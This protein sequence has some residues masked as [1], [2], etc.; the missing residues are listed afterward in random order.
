VGEGYQ[1]LKFGLFIFLFSLTVFS[2]TVVL[3]FAAM[4]GSFG[5]GWEV[6]YTAK[7]ATATLVTGAE[8]NDI[9]RYDININGTTNI[10]FD[11][12]KDEY[13]DV[14]NNAE[15]TYDVATADSAAD[16]ILYQITDTDGVLNLYILSDSEIFANV[17]C[18]SMFSVLLYMSNGN[19]VIEI[20]FNNFNT[21]KVENMSA[22]FNQSRAF[23]DIDLS[24]WDTSS[25]TDMSYMFDSASFN[26]LNLSGWDTSNVTSMSSMFYGYGG[27][28]ALDISSFDT[29]KVTSMT[30]MFSMCTTVKTI[31]VGSGWS[32]ASVTDGSGMFNMCRQLVGGDGT[33]YNSSYTNHTYARVDTAS[34]PGYF[35]LKS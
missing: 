9:L 13:N 24:G 31:Y 4:S 22:M 16:V 15:M 28:S 18:S 25:V 5:N 6:N 17:D 19:K 14:V 12:Y 2:S 34:T 11:Y 1:K 32:T 33:T 7:K 8:F 10:T 26:T 23:G 29:G 20:N 3:A 35:T 27:Q 21:S 30:A